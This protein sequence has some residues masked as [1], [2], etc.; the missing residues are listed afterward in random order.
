M[1][2]PH[3]NDGRTVLL[4]IAAFVSVVVGRGTTLAMAGAILLAEALA[5]RQG[6]IEGA[7]AV[8][9]VRLRPWAEAAQRMAR[10]NANL[11][12]PANRY[13]L[14]A[15]GAVLRSAARPFLA[16]WSGGC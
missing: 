11:F 10:R 9:E 12:T 3:W 6:R 2:K 8:Y 4:D 15:R 1:V 13:Q 14:L 16:Q 5:D 7:F